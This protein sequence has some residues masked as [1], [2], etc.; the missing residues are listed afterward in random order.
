MPSSIYHILIITVNDCVFSN[1][2]KKGIEVCNKQHGRCVFVKPRPPRNY[3]TGCSFLKSSL[4]M[5]LCVMCFFVVV[6]CLECVWTGGVGGTADGKLFQNH[7]HS[8]NIL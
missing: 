4:H 2:R 5:G 1:K 6:V 7:F 3:I 8:I